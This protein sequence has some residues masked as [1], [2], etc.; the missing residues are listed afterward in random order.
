[1]KN[2]YGTELEACVLNGLEESLEN[3]L[4]LVLRCSGPDVGLISAS[5]GFMMFEG[6]ISVIVNVIFF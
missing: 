6:F 4:N 2:D 5:E 3:K 1:V